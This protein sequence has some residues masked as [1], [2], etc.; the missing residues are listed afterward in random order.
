MNQR[1]SV[2]TEACV[3]SVMQAVPLEVPAH[4]SMQ[5]ACDEMRTRHV[6][7]A[8]IV[9]DRR[10]E[11][12]INNVMG[13]L[14][15]T[16]TLELIAHESKPKAVLVE[17]VMSSPVHTIAPAATLDTA[18]R[19]LHA[20]NIHRLPVVEAGLRYRAPAWYDEERVVRTWIV[21]TTATQPSR[22]A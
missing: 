10:I 7:E 3:R 14:T 22:V 19:A 13:I 8:L 20:L 16:D 9:A 21:S 5:H 17:H 4:T 2:E 15:E 1:A 6:E 11:R 12:R 18:W